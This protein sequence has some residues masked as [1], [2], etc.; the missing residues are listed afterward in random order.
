MMSSITSLSLSLSL[1]PLASTLEH[2]A[3]LKHFVS[4][5]FLNPKTIRRTPWTGD[6]PSARPLPMQTQNKHRKTSMP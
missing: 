2:R 3:S 4:L 5:Q 1:F 6:Q